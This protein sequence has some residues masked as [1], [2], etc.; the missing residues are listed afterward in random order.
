MN[1]QDIVRNL[2]KFWEEYGCTILYP[3]SSELGAGTLHPATS[4]EVLSGK[5]N[6]VAYL[7]PVVRPC[8]GRYGDN[9]NRLYQHHQYQ[10]IVQPSSLS[11][12]DDYLRSLELIGI[13]T[14][15]FDIR[16]IEDDWENPSIGAHGF[17]WEVS[18]NG[19]EITQFTYMQQVGGID[20]ELIPGEIAYGLER[21]AMV[22]QE[23]DTV[24]DIEW[25]NSGVVYGDIFKNREREFSALSFEHYDTSFLIDSFEKSEKM[26]ET[27]VENDVPIAGY[28]FC[29]K[30]SHIL[31]LLE[32]RGVIGVNERA[33]YILR[34]RKMTNMCCKSY[35]KL[36]KVA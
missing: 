33:S 35:V 14:K 12:R 3:Y 7:Q 10:V 15:D 18:C 31:N 4:M 8:D 26:C 2:E 5:K 32:A 23:K 30:A 13:S 6:M 22:L 29:V 27:M 17:G 21:I 9:Q 16:F 11:L 20:C 36:Y 24:Y 25:N 1:F 34:V 19:M 28:D